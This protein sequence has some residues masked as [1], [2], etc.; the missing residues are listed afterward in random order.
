MKRSSTYLYKNTQFLAT[1]YPE[2]P[3][4]N[5]ETDSYYQAILDSPTFHHIGV[6]CNNLTTPK[7][8]LQ[9]F[10]PDRSTFYSNF[11]EILY[12][13]THHYNAG[14][15]LHPYDISPS[16]LVYSTVKSHKETPTFDVYDKNGSN[17]QLAFFTNYTTSTYKLTD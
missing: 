15:L 11:F 10:T 4:N 6:D 16:K 3:F 7:L 8:S 9:L 14:R 2:I 1:L 13:S 12:S 17:G 5:D